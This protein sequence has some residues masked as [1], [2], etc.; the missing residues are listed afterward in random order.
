MEGAI[1][2]PPE[3][4]RPASLRWGEDWL[5]ALRFSAKDKED[6]TMNLFRESNP[7]RKAGG[8]HNYGI[9]S[10]AVMN[11]ILDHYDDC[12]LCWAV[13][14]LGQR[15]PS[16]Y[17]LYENSD[18]ILIPALGSFLPG[19]VLLVSR[20]HLGCLSSL[21][22]DALI[23]V[24]RDLDEID[25]FLRRYST[26]WCVFEH[27]K[28]ASDYPAGNT[29]DHLHLHFVPFKYDIVRDVSERLN[30]QP[31]PIKSITDLPV[32]CDSQKSN[33]VFLRDS[34]RN[35]YV[36]LAKTYPSQFV[37]QLIAIQVSQGDLWNWKESPL[38]DVCLTTIGG[39]KK[40]GLI[41]P[42]IYLAHSIEGRK[43]HEVERDI[44]TVRRFISSLPYEVK[45]ISMFEL[46][47]KRF[48]E[49]GYFREVDFNRM[50]VECEKR[51]MESCDLLLADLSIIGHQ[52]VGAL[53]EIA[54]AHN[55]GI[56]IIAFV[57]NS[58]IGS[59]LWLK[60]HCNYIV[61]DIVEATSLID[62]LL[63]QKCQST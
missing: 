40:A 53:M 34:H 24:E 50:L 27:G 4:D 58:S 9:L 37:R 6:M 31:K 46:L 48:F 2:C 18:Y 54:H 15:F 45:L 51:Y 43:P 41:R 13:S 56:P 21:S 16:N 28:T 19:Y 55:I 59:R 29:I 14:G 49:K 12:R 63:K 36:V 32:L 44:L 62:G 39:F 20:K 8:N 35:K 22:N 7:V 42:T 60:A 52:Y 61:N 38:E 17:I 1:S 5:K 47:E 23:T 26:S 57:G 3:A 30:V 25:R 11:E 10:K 33:Y